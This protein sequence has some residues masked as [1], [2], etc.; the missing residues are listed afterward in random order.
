MTSQTKR[1]SAAVRA[2]LHRPHFF[3]IKKPSDPDSTIAPAIPAEFT[4]DDPGM[5]RS[6]SLSPGDK[7][8]ISRL[9]PYDGIAIGEAKL[10]MKKRSRK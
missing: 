6:F 1:G 4:L 8:F 5:G 7:E 2:N 3:P 9:Y 10:P